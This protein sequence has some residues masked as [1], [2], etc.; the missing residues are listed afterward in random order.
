[1]CEQTNES[2]DNGRNSPRLLYTLSFWCAR[3]AHHWCAIVVCV[4]FGLVLPSLVWIASVLSKQVMSLCAMRVNPPSRLLVRETHHRRLVLG[5]S[6]QPSSARFP[7]GGRVACECT[8][9][10]RVSG[11]DGTCVV[12]ATKLVDDVCVCCTFR[13]GEGNAATAWARAPRRHERHPTKLC[14]TRRT[15]HELPVPTDRPRSLYLFHPP[16]AS[17]PHTACWN[18]QTQEA[19]V[20][21]RGDQPR[22]MQS[23][24]H[25]PP[26]Q[27]K[28]HPSPRKWHQGQRPNTQRIHTRPPPQLAPHRQSRRCQHANTRSR[29]RPTTSCT[30]NTERT[31]RLA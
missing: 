27:R 29:H 20:R 12:P 9:A 28:R 7:C 23:D 3:G 1:M 8:S 17:I 2:V 15:L 11:G 14:T 18:T 24:K 25:A 30:S 4:R 5:P 19:Q 31:P 26:R 10:P 21:L 6:A 16:Q 22:K 13:E